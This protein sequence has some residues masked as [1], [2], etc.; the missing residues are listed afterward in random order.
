MIGYVAG[1]LKH[2]ADNTIIILVGGV[3]YEIEAHARLIQKLP[4]IG[5]E[6][7]VYTYQHVREDQHQL[8]G[9]IDNN[10]KNIFKLLL[11][12]NGVGPKLAQTIFSTL[13]AKALVK[14][15]LHE[16]YT[17]LRLVKG[18]GVKVAKRLVMDLKTPFMALS[19]LDFAAENKPESG[20][21][22]W[23]DAV[24]VL[25]RLGYK[26]ALA[27]KTVVALKDDAKDLDSLI[28]TALKSISKET[29]SI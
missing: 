24:Q 29:A 2:V 14:S 16:D 3:G 21:P 15:I 13:D 25:T 11:K 5:E 9:F 7:E 4:F 10:E 8:F 28:R 26:H 19:S 18:L 22:N 6:V 27:E 20:L 17:S 1:K 23:Q 12:V